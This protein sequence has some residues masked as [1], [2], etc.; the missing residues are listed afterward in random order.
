MHIFKG[1]DL[2]KFT[3]EFKT[4]NNCKEYLSKIKWRQGYKCVKCGHTASQIREDYSRLSS[5]IVNCSANK[6]AVTFKINVTA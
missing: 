5:C 2:L 3:K 6:K 4:D 1:Q